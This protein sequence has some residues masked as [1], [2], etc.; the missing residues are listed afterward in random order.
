MFWVENVWYVCIVERTV[1]KPTVGP[2]EEVVRGVWQSGA[3]G[4]RSPSY[5]L[6]PVSPQTGS[7][8][9][10]EELNSAVSHSFWLPR[11][12][13]SFMKLFSSPH[14]PSSFSRYRFFLHYVNSWVGTGVTVTFLCSSVY[15]LPFSHSTSVSLRGHLRDLYLSVLPHTFSGFILLSMG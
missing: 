10:M 4:R 14:T 6:L 1:G 11:S 5:H 3:K 13:F 12:E 9:R 7:P 15:T 2:S 8:L